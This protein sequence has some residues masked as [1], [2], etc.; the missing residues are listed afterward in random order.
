MQSLFEMA[1]LLGHRVDVDEWLETCQ[2]ALCSPSPSFLPTL[3]TAGLISVGEDSNSWSFANAMVAECLV[4]LS[5][6]AGRWTYHNQIC[7]E[8]LEGFAGSRGKVG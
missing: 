6:E 7:A 2:K 5:K 4:R 1:A 3:E 8:I